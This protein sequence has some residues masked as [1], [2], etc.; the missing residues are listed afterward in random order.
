MDRKARF[1]TWSLAAAGIT[2]LV[3]LVFHPVYLG[4]LWVSGTAGWLAFLLGGLLVGL[5]F[6]P[7]AGAVATSPGGT[8]ISLARAAAGSPGAVGTALLVGGLLVYHAG[9]TL[10]EASEMAVTM[11]FPHT[12][13][14]MAMVAL[15]MGAAYGA[16][17]GIDAIVFLCRA[18]LPVLLSLLLLVA[19]GTLGWG[20]FRYLLPLWGHGGRPLGVG[21]LLTVAIY[22]PMLFLLV[23]SANLH[24]RRQLWKAALAVAGVATICF[25]VLKVVLL[26]VFPYPLGESVAFP[27]HA[28]TRLVLGGR[29]LE[30]IESLWLFFWVYATACHLGAVLHTAAA[31]YA[32]A[33][34]FPS[35]R[36]AVLPLILLAGT[37]ALFPPD[38]SQTIGWHTG[39]APLAATIGFGLPLLLTGA[40]ALRRRLTHHG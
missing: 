37:I 17:G 9:L 15:V 8:L 1:G 33:V 35:H 31:M 22:T 4:P 39:A 13:Q 11:V 21:S 26:M 6:W 20:E 16:Y 32:E 19:I 40:A 2:V 18:F 3:S 29:F 34:G 27:I 25:T 30:R 24:D 14:T 5:L 28:L 23:G 12:P 10:R 36:T 7:V 38:I